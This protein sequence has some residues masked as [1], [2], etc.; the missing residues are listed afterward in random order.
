MFLMALSSRTPSLV[1]SIARRARC[2]ACS[3]PA[4]DHRLDDAVYVFLCVLGEY[5]RGI[6]SAIEQ[7][8]QVCD[9]LF[10]ELICWR[11]YLNLM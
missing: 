9:S 2:C 10:V 3:S 6:A 7:I 11:G 4:S 1:S 5:S 8:L